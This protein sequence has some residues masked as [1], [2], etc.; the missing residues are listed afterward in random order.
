M[1]Q[2]PAAGL[3][4][5][6]MFML[7]SIFAMHA[8]GD[9]SSSYQQRIDSDPIV[10]RLFAQF[11]GVVQASV[12][13]EAVFE[14]AH[15]PLGRYPYSDGTSMALSSDDLFPI[16]SITKQ[17]VAALILR[18]IQERE[19]DLTTSIAHVLPGT[20]PHWKQI[21]IT[22]L[23]THSSGIADQ[24]S[25]EL[26]EGFRNV[27]LNHV[28]I[29]ERLKKI[30]LRM[31]PVLSPARPAKRL[32]S[33]PVFGYSNGNYL[34]LS[35]ILEE[36]WK[37]KHGQIKSWPEILRDEV[38]VPFGLQDT[39]VLNLNEIPSRLLIGFEQL[40]LGQFGPAPLLR[41]ALL[42]G[43]GDIVSSLKDLSRWTHI[44]FE[45]DFIL[46]APSRNLLMKAISGD[47]TFGGR[48][49]AL[50]KARFHLRTGTLKGYH[51]AL[52]YF[53]DFRL[54]I[55]V[56]SHQDGSPVKALSERIAKILLHG[57]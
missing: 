41:P 39:S 53:P 25:T 12:A 14:A 57:R 50:E 6:L 29:F 37:K 38:I 31:L 40:R 7:V 10:Q 36:L 27:D 43:C 35:L 22:H 1:K 8:S 30:E 34:A 19:I 2:A 44:L 52:V 51:H 5:A 15:G 20:P 56:L 9:G 21:Q 55:I 47:F 32:N 16:A 24:L 3:R 54:S 33:S 26:I 49:G 46:K 28:G 11:S 4:Q 23:L 42:Y 13:G 18:R 17:F 48:V 45:T